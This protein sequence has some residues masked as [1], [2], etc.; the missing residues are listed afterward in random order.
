MKIK[1]VSPFVLFLMMLYNISFAQTI[2]FTGKA[3]YV[4]ET[5]LPS[6]NYKENVKT[7]S[8]FNEIGY[9]TR[10][11]EKR[12]NLDDMIA[13]QL[14]KVIQAYNAEYN[15]RPE[16]T[17]PLDSFEIE[18]HR[19]RIK[20][21]LE[22]AYSKIPPLPITFIGYSASISNM[23]VKIDSLYYCVAD[24]LVKTD[25][26]L[27]DDTLTIDGLHCQK[28]EGVYQGKNLYEVWFAPSVP[29]GVG[30]VNMHGLPGIIVS[31][32]SKDKKRRYQLTK[33]EYP[34]STPVVLAGCDVTENRISRQ[35]FFQ[36]QEQHKKEQQKKRESM[37][38]N[39]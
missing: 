30:P 10:Q 9:C 3:E 14:K 1:I 6:G 2:S 29:F 18:K 19:S 24:T 25:W 5:I 13:N 17:A 31:A 4:V 15:K 33:L 32:T 16:S 36:L 8:Y 21:Q 26:L 12:I 20:A 7:T 34:L 37:K 11:N 38:S 28:A 35:E 39:Q 27:L 23:P 22:E